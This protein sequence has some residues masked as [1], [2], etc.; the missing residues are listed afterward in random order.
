MRL[1]ARRQA[2]GA[3]DGM[4]LI[5]V[6]VAMVIFGM[7]AVFSTT[8]WVHYVRAQELRRSADEVT[9]VLRNAQELALSEAATYCVTFGTDNRSYVMTKYACG[10]AG[11]QVGSTLRTVSSRVTFGSAAFTQPD[12]TVTRGVQFTMRGSAS[13]GSVTLQRQGSS[14]TYTISVEGLTGRVSLG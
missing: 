9:A 1:T 13:P 14:K 5:E 3:D 4:T 10:A 6:L 7:L 11:T 8:G 2:N 12:G